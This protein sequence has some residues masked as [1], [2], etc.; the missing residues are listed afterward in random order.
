MRKMRIKGGHWVSKMRAK[1]KKMT[2]T[3][4]STM[5]QNKQLKWA[6]W[7]N[8]MWMGIMYTVVFLIVCC[9][10]PCWCILHSSAIAWW[11]KT[12]RC[13]ENC[14]L[15]SRTFVLLMLFLHVP[16]AY[17]MIHVI[18]AEGSKID[19]LIKRPLLL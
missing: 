4:V 6:K 13:N 15:T 19:Y 12:L 9:N 16:I 2:N 11:C 8:V 17:E 5:R 14:L 1:C 3:T 7:E 10:Y 18:N